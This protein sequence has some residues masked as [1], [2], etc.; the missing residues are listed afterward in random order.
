[1]YM[2]VVGEPGI[3][4]GVSLPRSPRLLGLRLRRAPLSTQAGGTQLPSPGASHTRLIF[5]RRAARPG[6][7]LGMHAGTR[8]RLSLLTRG[9]FTNKIQD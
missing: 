1:S 9:R 7:A 3:W 4:Q 8:Q 6:E 2:P 5:L